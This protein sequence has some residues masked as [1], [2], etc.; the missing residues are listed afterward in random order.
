MSKDE[1]GIDEAKHEA[2]MLHA[3]AVV[4]SGTADRETQRGCKGKTTCNMGTP[5]PGNVQS[6][7][8]TSLKDENGFLYNCFVNDVIEEKWVPRLEEALKKRGGGVVGDVD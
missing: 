6:S 2:M 7:N 8:D 4:P 3:K 5:W 1:L